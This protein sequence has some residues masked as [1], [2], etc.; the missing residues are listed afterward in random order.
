[1][2]VTWMVTVDSQIPE[3]LAQLRLAM[4]EGAEQGSQIVSDAAV[5]FVAVD[6]GSLLHTIDTELAED[7]GDIVQWS[8][9]A[10]NLQGGYAGGGLTDKPAGA[11]V[12]YAE[13][14]EFGGTA[15]KHTPF[16]TPAAEI[17][18]QEYQALVEEL[19]GGI[20]L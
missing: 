8:V 14:Q 7:A 13:A 19:L 2:S 1:M 20:V 3:Y 16:M 9:N 17:G 5:R 18:W 12:D 15:A 10:G 4:H 11:P 6:T